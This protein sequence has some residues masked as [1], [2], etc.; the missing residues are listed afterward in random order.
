MSSISF[1]IHVKKR[2]KFYFIFRIPHRKT[3]QLSVS[4]TLHQVHLSQFPGA[5]IYDGQLMARTVAARLPIPTFS[6]VV[7]V[8]VKSREFDDVPGGS[9]IKIH[10]LAPLAHTHTRTHVR[11]LTPRFRVA[12]LHLACAISLNLLLS[13]SPSQG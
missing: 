5:S 3:V 13:F 6:P 4:T 11:E 12:A 10:H 8:R 7:Q 2:M 9:I 1:C